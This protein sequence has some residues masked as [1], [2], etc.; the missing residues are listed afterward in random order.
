MKSEFEDRLNRQ[1][2]EHFI[3]DDTEDTGL[4]N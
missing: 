2:L 3:W 4:K 1:R